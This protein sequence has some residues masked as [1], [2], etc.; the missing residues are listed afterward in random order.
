MDNQVISVIIP[1]FD[2]A[3]CL[4]DC[5]R[6]VVS[7]TYDNLEIILVDDASED[8]SGA[9]CDSWAERDSRIVVVRH[10]ENR[11]LSAARNIGLDCASG[12]FVLFVD[13]DDVVAET[14][15]ETLHRAIVEMHVPC[16]MCGNSLRGV[17]GRELEFK[18]TETPRVV[19]A[20]D[21][22]AQALS[23]DRETIIANARETI[24]SCHTPADGFR[25]KSWGQKHLT[26]TADCLGGQLE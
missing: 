16:V 18:P 2:V 21:C 22:F 24:R 23:P 17:T 11:G 19:T 14:F 13:S 4:D 15:A 20:H 5:L 7:Q 3:A 12:E 10:R 8:G 9:L 25:G 6:S 26:L 1:V